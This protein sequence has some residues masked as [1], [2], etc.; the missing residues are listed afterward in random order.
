MKQQQ[1]RL[2][3]AIVSAAAFVLWTILIRTAD[4][5][6][7]GPCGSAVGLAGFNQCI[8]NLTGVHWDAYVL[9]DWLGL[10]PITFAMGFAVTGLMQWIRRKRLREVDRSLRMLG[11]LY[12][13]AA[14]AYAFFEVVIVNYRPVLIG[15]VLEA[16]YPS[17]T[18]VLT[19]CVMLPAIRRWNARIRGRALQRTVTW[20]LTAFTA[21]MVLARLYAGVHWCSDIIGGILLSATLLLLYR[22]LCGTEE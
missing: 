18:T 16:S 9:T 4:V 6:A 7:I 19:L 5:R 12:L 10:V 3:C 1:K 20:S 21:A 15:G 14:A 13:S 11:I 22:F 17:S 8:H 2:L